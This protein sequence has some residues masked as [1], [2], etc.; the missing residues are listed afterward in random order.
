MAKWLQKSAE[1]LYAKML[2]NLKKSI[3]QAYLE[4]GTYDQIVNYLEREMEL[5]GLESDGTLVKT[6]MTVT[7]KE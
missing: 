7:K 3:N 2:P 5:N 4:N 6:Q 1:T